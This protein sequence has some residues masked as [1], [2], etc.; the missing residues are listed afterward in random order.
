MRKPEMQVSVFNFKVLVLSVINELT[1]IVAA[2][3]EYN[4]TV[5]RTVTCTMKSLYIFCYSHVFSLAEQ[6]I[7][8]VHKKAF[9]KV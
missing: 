2:F 5:N 3:I 8:L 9:E 6:D 7:I 1:N 4:A